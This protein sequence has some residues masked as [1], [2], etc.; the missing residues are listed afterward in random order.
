VPEVDGFAEMLAAI[1]PTAA[2]KLGKYI[3]GKKLKEGEKY[4]FLML[5]LL[6]EEVHT[7]NSQ[8]T[9]VYNLE[10]ENSGK[11]DTILERS[12]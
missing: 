5:A 12:R 4:Q 1:A 8:L 6:F 7:T 10:V 2:E 11:L 3:E 9:K